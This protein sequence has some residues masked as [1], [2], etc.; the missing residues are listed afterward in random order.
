MFNI[1]HAMALTPLLG[2]QYVP[3]STISYTFN[4]SCLFRNESAECECE[5]T[6][7]ETTSTPS[8]LVIAPSSPARD[9]VELPS[10]ENFVPSDQKER[11]PSESQE[12]L[13]KLQDCN[14]K[15]VEDELSRKWETF[16]AEL[17]KAGGTGYEDDKIVDEADEQDAPKAG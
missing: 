16:R 15:A 9:D 4:F 13:L 17:I 11:T 5:K 6:V 10:Q 8:T 2:N 14:I 3:N 7:D 1:N 12:D